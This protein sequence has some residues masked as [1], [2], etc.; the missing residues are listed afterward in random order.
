MPSS[1]RALI[2]FVVV[3][4]SA[5]CFADAADDCDRLASHPYDAGN[6]PGIRGVAF[7]EIEPDAA[8]AACAAAVAARP[9]LPRYIYLLGRSVHAGN[10]VPRAV[11]LYRTAGRAGYARAWMSLGLMHAQGDYFDQDMGAAVDAF[12]K[13]ADLGDPDGLSELAYHYEAGMGVE[14]D[15]S[16]A[17][18][19]YREAAT[20]GRQ[21]SSGALEAFEAISA[22]KSAQGC[23]TARYSGDSWAFRIQEGPDVTDGY[24]IEL[25]PAVLSQ[26]TVVTVNCLRGKSCM[27]LGKREG[28]KVPSRSFRSCTA[29]EASLLAQRLA[30]AIGGR[31]RMQLDRQ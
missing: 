6:P 28:I 8:K 29:N 2:V 19:L 30:T 9:G 14:A 10:D 16:K 5:P 24:L 3:L 4:L 7:D 20:S 25:D 17:A 11:E 18:I 12:R 21:G 15:L 27:Q 13:A 22:L 31:Q 26:D 1:M 23:D